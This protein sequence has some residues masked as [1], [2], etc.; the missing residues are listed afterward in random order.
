MEWITKWIEWKKICLKSVSLDIFNAEILSNLGTMETMCRWGGERWRY[1]WA[2]RANVAASPQAVLR[3]AL[4]A[5]VVISLYPISLLFWQLLCSDN[6]WRIPPTMPVLPIIHLYMN[7]VD[8]FYC[9]LL[10][11]R[12]DSTLDSMTPDFSWIW[13][14]Q[15]S[16]AAFFSALDLCTHEISMKCL[17]DV[18]IYSYCFLFLIIA[19]SFPSHSHI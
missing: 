5:V 17:A 16:G 15:C 8:I 13:I 3:N 9:S 18:C 2:L 19:T 1:L 6:A 4:V 11:F 7:I 12:P 10:L 14:V